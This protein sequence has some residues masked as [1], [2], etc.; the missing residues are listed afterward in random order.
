MLVLPAMVNMTILLLKETAVLS[1]IS[2]QELTNVAAVI[3]SANYAYVTAFAVLALVY[4]ALVEVCGAA[5]RAAEARLSR[6]RFAAHE[7]DARDPRHRSGQAL[8]RDTSARRHRPRGA[9]WRGRV[10]ARPVGLRQEHALRCVGHLEVPTDGLIEIDG[11]AIGRRA[12][13]SGT[14]IALPQ[15]EI[16]RVRRHIGMVFQQFNLWPH[17]T[18]LGN[19]IGSAGAPC[20]ACRARRPRRR[21]DDAAREGRARRQG[22]AITPRELSGGQQQRV[23]IARALAHGAR[24]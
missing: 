9:P 23:A 16:R 21:R 12:G 19:V 8:L 4:W 3:G 5:G 24:R 6:Y 10:P 15:A 13:P 11:G 2:V 1:V 17:M 22:D 20:A 7:P 18:A 14:R